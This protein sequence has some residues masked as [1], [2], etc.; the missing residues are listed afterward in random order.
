LSRSIEK[1]ASY[2]L[3]K[4]KSCLGNQ[5]LDLSKRLSVCTDGAPSMIGKAA[6]AVAMLKSFFGRPL[7]KYH[8]IIHQYSLCGKGL[9]L[10]HV[11]VP[12]VKCEQN[13]SK[14]IKQKTIQRML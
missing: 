9:S 10:Q 2:T 1:K 14:R 13:Y 6:R 4:V 5:Q 8:C 11:M 12:V 3:E 7:L